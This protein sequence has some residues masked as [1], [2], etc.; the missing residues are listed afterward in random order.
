VILG[1]MLHG[2]KATR[3]KTYVSLA[4]SHK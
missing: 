4:H 3:E 2:R 1:M